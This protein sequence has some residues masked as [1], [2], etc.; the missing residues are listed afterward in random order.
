MPNIRRGV[1]SGAS[2][3][4]VSAARANGAIIESSN[5]SDSAMPAP[6]RKRR[7]EMARRVTTNGAGWSGVVGS[8][9]SVSISFQ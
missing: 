2:G 9:E 3:D 8:V 5:G 1:A 7:R 6:R 4:D